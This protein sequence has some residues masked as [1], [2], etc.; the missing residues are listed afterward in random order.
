MSHIQRTHRFGLL[1]PSSNSTQEPEFVEVLPRTV[2]LHCARLTLSNVDADSTA[3][4]VEELEKESAKL[5]DAAVDAIVLAATAPS[6]RFG[7]GYDVEL[8]KRITKASGKP[9]TTASTGTLEALAKLGVTRISIA[10]PW[11]D[12]VNR[13][14]AAFFE[15]NGITVVHHQ[16]MG[17]VRNN[18]IGLLDPQTAFDLGREVDRAASQAVL[19]A[20]GNWW[21]QS[22]VE[23]LE[24]TIG[25]PVVTTNSAAIWSTLNLMG[26][27]D[28]ITGFGTL[29]RDHR[30][31]AKRPAQ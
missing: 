9:G 23:R 18:E 26:C 1:L 8:V 10:A 5:A 24:K 27:S 21:T 20:C 28:P 25:K 3:R 15:A 12:S 13:T 6:S 29:L 7:K 19:L 31:P 30:V 14:V 4:M 22:I 11:S 17:L 16:A 2:S